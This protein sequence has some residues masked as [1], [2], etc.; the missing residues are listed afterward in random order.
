M[1]KLTTPLISIGAPNRSYALGWVVSSNQ[2]WTKGPIFW[3]EGSNTLWHAAIIVAPASGF[4]V[5]AVSNDEARGGKAVETLFTKLI[6]QF[7]APAPAQTPAQ[8]PPQP[9]PH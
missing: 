4:A 8:T 1:A 2:P 3:H 5:L 6:H 7:A 9:A